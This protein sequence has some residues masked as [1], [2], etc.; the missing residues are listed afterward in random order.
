[1]KAPFGLVKQFKTSLNFSDLLIDVGWCGKIWKIVLWRSRCKVRCNRVRLMWYEIM[2][3]LY[4]GV[5][6]FGLIKCIKMRCCVIRIGL[7][8]CVVMWVVCWGVVWCD[9]IWCSVVRLMIFEVWCGM[10]WC[11]LFWPGVIWCCVVSCEGYFYIIW[12]SFV[13]WDYFRWGF[14]R[15]VVLCPGVGW[16]KVWCGVV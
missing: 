5:I 10:E 3:V 8:E 13:W 4:C 1:M 9:V 7:I 15:P 16:E 11:G 2:C 12:W 6:R 14:L